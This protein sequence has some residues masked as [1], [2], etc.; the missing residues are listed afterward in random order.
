MITHTNMA[1]QTDRLPQHIAIIMDGNGR[2][3]L[4]RGEER[5]HGH[6]HAVGVIEELIEEVLRLKIP[7]LTLYAFSTENWS[8][9]EKEI[10]IIM[11][12]LTKVIVQKAPALKEKNVRLNFIGDRET[13][14]PETLASV[15]Q[16][17]AI[18]QDSKALW[19]NVALNYSGRWEILHA[20]KQI[21]RQV[22]QKELSA[23]NLTEHT[24]SQ[25]LQTADMPD[26]ELLIRTGGEY[27]IS[28]FL[29]W[30]LAYT[31]LY[32]TDIKFPSFSA[33]A[34]QHAI[35]AYQ[36]RERRFGSC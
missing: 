10:M 3:A 9:P 32:I 24:I 18:T 28:N 14:S 17:E 30:Q 23:N 29:L 1:L 20:M 13:L 8:R 25:H 26:P 27:R 12:L 15:Q 34:L 35:K 31:E 4:E 33:E 6:S 7:Y 11:D 36:K 22:E 19:L 21:A 5:T 2:W 16:G